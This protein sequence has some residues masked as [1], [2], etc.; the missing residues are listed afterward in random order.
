MCRNLKFYPHDRFFFHRHRRCVGDKYQVCPE[1]C[2]DLDVLGGPLPGLV[3]FNL[4]WPKKVCF[5]STFQL[6]FLLA[7]NVSQSLQ[8]SAFNRDEH[9]CTASAFLRKFNVFI[10]CRKFNV[11]IFWRK[12]NVPFL[13][14]FWR[15]IA[16]NRTLVQ[17]HIRNIVPQIIL[18]KSLKKNSWQQ[19]LKA[20]CIVMLGLDMKIDPLR[21][22]LKKTSKFI[23][24]D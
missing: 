19:V 9:N 21:L 8:T 7:W 12:F 5:C 20:H 17:P 16:N 14:S 22:S 18:K 15:D 13:N 3:L 2:K 24:Y 11:S 1:V 10:F 4:F 23:I 6:Y